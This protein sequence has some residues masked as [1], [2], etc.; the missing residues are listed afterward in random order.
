MAAPPKLRRFLVEGNEQQGR[1]TQSNNPEYRH[2]MRFIN[3]S[4]FL[5]TAAYH[6]VYYMS[7]S[8]SIKDLHALTIDILSQSK[9]LLPLGNEYQ[10]LD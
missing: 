3:F 5:N 4:P 1:R 9:Y 8:P 2:L 7:S 10:P 6:L